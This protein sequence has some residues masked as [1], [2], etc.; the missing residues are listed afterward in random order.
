MEA[1]LNGRSELEM[2]GND[3]PLLHAVQFLTERFGALEDKVD[4]VR[5]G[6][7]GKV[8]QAG[9]AEDMRQ[10]QSTILSLAS[11]VT[12]LE[13]GNTSETTAQKD[14]RAQITYGLIG[15]AGTIGAAV[16]VALGTLAAR[17]IP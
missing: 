10:A 6:L 3:S 5:E 15:V 7:L 2:A 16:V 13:S 11:R 9:L 8:G 4:E 14:R 1:A 12:Q 17:L